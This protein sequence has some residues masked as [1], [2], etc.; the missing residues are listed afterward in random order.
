MF[1]PV[2][3]SMRVLSSR[4]TSLA[5]KGVLSTCSTTGWR[6][7]VMRRQGSSTKV[8]QLRSRFRAR[9]ARLL[10]TSSSASAAAVSCSGPRCSI[11]ISISASYSSFSRA[12]ARLLADSALS[13]KALSSGVMKR[14]APLRVWRRM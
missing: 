9:S 11:R 6:P 8:G 7:W 10:S 2:M 5:T 4:L 12:S 14:S 13:S 3:I 1:G